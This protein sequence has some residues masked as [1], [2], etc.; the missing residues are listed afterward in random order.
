MRKT[1]HIR[2][3][4]QGS[5]EVRYSLGIYPATGKRRVATATVR[6]TRKEAE[7]ELRRL[8]RTLDTNEHVDA[9]RMTIR[10]WL[11]KW[12]V[13]VREEVS[14]KSYERYSE[15]VWGFLAPELRCPPRWQARTQPYPGGVYQMGD[16][17]ATGRQARRAF[18][19]NEAPY[20]SHPQS[21]AWPRRRDA[22]SP[23]QSG[24]C[25][26]KASP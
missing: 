17:G 4:T 11:T 18:T 14:P 8:L 2:Q 22:G 5:W 21:R 25:L 12:L 9:S 16:R 23:P 1:G 10:N 6:G 7:L 20:P 24:R 3:R 13:A 26:Q 19:S 15:I